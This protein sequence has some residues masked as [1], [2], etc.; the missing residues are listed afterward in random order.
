[1][2]IIRLSG[3][4]KYIFPDFHKSAQRKGIIISLAEITE[5]E[6]RYFV[7][8][9]YKGSKYFGWQRQPDKLS[10]QEAIEDCLSRIF[11]MP[12][13]IYGCG[14]TDT[15]VHASQY[16]F[17]MDI[18]KSWSFDLFFRLNR[19]L[20]D[21]ISLFDIIPVNGDKHARHDA[22]Q[23]EYDYFI[24]TYKDPFL[25]ESSSLYLRKSFNLEQMK[26]AVSLLPKYNDY[27][28][29]C[30]SPNKNEHTICR[31]SAASLY[32]NTNGDRIR[33]NISSNR[34]LGRMIRI[35]SRKL[36]EIGD[37]TLSVDEFE[38]HLISKNIPSKI[39]PAHPQGLYLSKVT[40]PFLD[41][42]P[43]AVHPGS[44]QVW[45]EV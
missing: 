32:S 29:F 6:M 38:S 18:E 20:P 7:H 25:S 33:F 21:D 11:K 9:A 45:I 12:V 16:F 28:A 22:I 30:K 23:R 5:R 44:E 36:I 3:K 31:V 17:H 39:L 24:H 15:G 42:K 10:V 2:A 34:F 37:G 1:L 41:L 27:R 35:L 4:Q 40:Y 43:K 14:R 13:T 26:K 8:I 19:T